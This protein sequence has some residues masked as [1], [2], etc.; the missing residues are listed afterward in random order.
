[1]PASPPPT[2]PTPVDVP[3]FVVDEALAKR[4]RKD[5]AE[6]CF[7]CHGAGAVSGGMGPDL[8]ASAVS[9]TY[10]GFSQIVLNG[11]QPNGMPRFRD[12]SQEDVQ[13]LYHYVRMQARKAVEAKQ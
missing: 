13:G 6:T 11:I 2:F 4:G 9:T 1:M 3:G 10:D 12:F 8:R 5:F 7:F